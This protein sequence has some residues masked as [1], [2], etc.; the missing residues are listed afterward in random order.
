MKTVKHNNKGN[1]R[2]AIIIVVTAWVIVLGIIYTL[3][4]VII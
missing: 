3:A 4:R 1:Q 2:E